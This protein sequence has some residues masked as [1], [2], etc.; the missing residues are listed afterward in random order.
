MG[1]KYL[2]R[3][4]DALATD[5]RLVIIGMQGGTKAE[6]NI[7]AL[8]SGSAARSP[9]RRCAPGRPTEKAAIVAERPRA[10]LAADRRPALYG[11]SC[12]RHVPLDEVAE[13][14]RVLEDGVSTIGKVL[15]TV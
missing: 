7:G 13:A 9:R 2:A 12:T 1:A 4:V 14:H 10:R 8:I 6:L 3:N 15:L 5:G 11:R